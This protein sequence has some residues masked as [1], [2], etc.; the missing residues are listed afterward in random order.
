M[1]PSLVQLAEA[2]CCVKSTALAALD[3][4]EHH[5]WVTRKRSKG[6]RTKKT[7]YQLLPGFPCP[8]DCPKRSGRRTV[9]QRKRSD[10]RTPK[11]SD[12]HM[13]NSRPDPVLDVGISE[14]KGWQ[15]SAW[16]AGSEGEYANTV[17]YAYDHAS[18]PAIDGGPHAR[19]GTA[20]ASQ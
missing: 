19:A 13:Q 16:P 14:G 1:T 7:T 20:A 3:H 11:R 6:G 18:A 12:S 5:A 10:S 2:V 9:S 8:P 17:G 4:V 15:G